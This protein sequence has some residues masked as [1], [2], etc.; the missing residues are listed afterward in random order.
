MQTWEDMARLIAQSR[1]ASLRFTVRRDGLQVS[2]TVQPR[3][4][5][6]PATSSAKRAAAYLIGVTSAGETF[7]RHLNLFQAAGQALVQTYKITELTVLS[8][9]K[10]IQGSISAKTLGGPIMIAEMA[11]QQAREGAVNLLFFI[12][13]IS[14]NLAILNFLPIPVLDGGHLLFFFIEMIRGRPVSLRVRE[15]AQQAGMFL[16]LMLMILVFYNDITR[17]ITS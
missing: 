16:L 1:G 14:I 7:I 3:E 8:V 5:T 9:V 11:G 6:S 13:L 15:V 2:A 10:I 4:D 12:A 17:I